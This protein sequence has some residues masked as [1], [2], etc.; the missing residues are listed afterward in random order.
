MATTAQYGSVAPYYEK[1]DLRPSERPIVYYPSPTKAIA[2][3]GG[4]SYSAEFLEG[5]EH[6]DAANTEFNP[7]NNIMF[8]QK[9]TGY[10]KMYFKQGYTQIRTG[11]STFTR[12]RYKV[13]ADL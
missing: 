9:G 6:Q 1:E 4:V 7:A 8:F 3:G 10:N 13:N 12:Y 2:F 5:Y 11:A